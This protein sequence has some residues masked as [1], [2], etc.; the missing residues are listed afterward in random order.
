[1][2]RIVLAEDHFVMRQKLKQL[3]AS[4][5]DVVVVGE[6]A[7][8]E[9]ALRLTLELQPDVLLTDLSMPR[10]HGLE[11]T[12]RL[13]AEHSAARVVIVSVTT[14]EPYVLAALRNGAQGYVGKDSC[15]QYLLPAIEAVQSGQQYLAPPLDPNL[16][17]RYREST[18]SAKVEK[19]VASE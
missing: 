12:L 15:R 7:D 8:G 18:D 4:R 6:A 1:M 11:L 5:G 14:E 19:L 3:L 17:V 2:T 16:L 13:Q 9:E 10:L